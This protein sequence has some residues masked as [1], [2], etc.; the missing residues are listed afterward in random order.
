MQLVVRGPGH[1]GGSSDHGRWNGSRCCT[2]ACV[3]SAGSRLA[4]KAVEQAAQRGQHGHHGRVV[5]AQ[6]LAPDG[7]E[8]GSVGHGKRAGPQ[9]NCG[10][11]RPVLLHVLQYLL[12]MRKLYIV[13]SA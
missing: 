3:C 5:L 2:L 4:A 13:Q 1:K 7:V 8:G 6:S 12:R 10:L 9:A 11:V